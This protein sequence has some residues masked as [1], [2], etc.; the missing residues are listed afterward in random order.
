MRMVMYKGHP[1]THSQEQVAFFSFQDQTSKRLF[2]DREQK[3]HSGLNGV[4]SNDPGFCSGNSFCTRQKE[5]T[6]AF[7]RHSSSESWSSRVR[8]VAVQVLFNTIVLCNLDATCWLFPPSL[9]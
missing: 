6:E 5:H 2:I 4:Y 8:H 9:I 3:Q 1:L 7:S